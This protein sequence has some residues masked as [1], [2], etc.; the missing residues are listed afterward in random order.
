M[1]WEMPSVSGTAFVTHHSEIVSRREEWRLTREV[2]RLQVTCDLGFSWDSIGFNY[3]LLWIIMDYY[4]LL[5]IIMDYYGL[6]WIIMDYYGLLWIIVDYCVTTICHCGHQ[7]FTG[8]KKSWFLMG[9]SSSNNGDFSCKTSP[10]E[11]GISTTNMGFHLQ[12]W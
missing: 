7:V 11:M 2:L 6:L 12:K 8:Q 10:T 3:G 5:W 4:G 1:N 9:R